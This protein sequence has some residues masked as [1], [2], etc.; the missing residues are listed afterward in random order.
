MAT[1]FYLHR[2]ATTVTGTLPA[3]GS[4][5]ASTVPVQIASG[6]DT[7]RAMDTTISAVSQTSI[8]LTTLANQTAQP[9]LLLRCI[10]DQIAAQTIAAQTLSIGV[11]IS[12]SNSNSNFRLQGCVAVWR[13]SDGSL[14]GR[15]CEPLV[16]PFFLSGAA[17]ATTSE[18]WT[19]GSSRTTTAVTCSNGDVLVVELWRDSTAQGMST[20]YTNTVFYDGTTEGSATN[21]AIFVSFPNTITFAGSGTT[22]TK[23]G[24]AVESA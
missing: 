9:A 7:N 13:P 24:F 22:Y 3:A 10:S 18:A 8:A 12:E 20:S 1:K 11:A 2:G 17:I 15:L 4:S 19:S 14:V 16:S 23:S 21:A 5:V 6:G